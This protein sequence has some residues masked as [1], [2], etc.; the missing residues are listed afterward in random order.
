MVSTH[1]LVCVHFQLMLMQILF[2][3]C[4]CNLNCRD[5]KKRKDNTSFSWLWC[6]NLLVCP[7]W[8]RVAIAAN[9]HVLIGSATHLRSWHFPGRYLHSNCVLRSLEQQ[10]RYGS[11]EGSSVPP[12]HSVIRWKVLNLGQASI[13]Y[14]HSTHSHF[15]AHQSGRLMGDAEAQQ[16]TAFRRAIAVND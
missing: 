13:I 10:R 15:I 16:K 4:R 2:R 9:Q 5:Y 11:P 1:N 14:I 3:N 12:L 6:E 8:S 7:S